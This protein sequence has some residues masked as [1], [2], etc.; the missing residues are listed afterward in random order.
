MK[1]FGY[2]ALAAAVMLSFSGCNDK[3]AT[4][5]TNIDLSSYPIKTDET[6][7]YWMPLDANL[8][9]S[10]SNFGETEYAKELEKRTGVKIEYIHPAAG[11]QSEAL[12]VMIASDELTD[13]VQTDWQ[14]GY[15][16]GPG[17]AISDEVIISLNDYFKKYA[18]SFSKVLSEHPEINKEIKTDEGQYYVFPMLRLS[19]KVRT[20]EG[21]VLRADWLRELNLKAPETI[22][23]WEEVLRAFKDKKHAGAPMCFNYAYIYKFINMMGANNGQYVKDGKIIY[24]PTE[25]E[26]KDA[27]ERMRKW[28]KEGLLDKNIASVDAKM[29]DAN[30]LNGNTGAAIMTGG[31]GIGKYLDS[32]E[33]KNFDL[34][35]VKMPGISKGES[36]NQAFL[37]ALYNVSGSVGISS[38]C[39]NPALAV[40]Y[41]DYNYSEEGHM[42]ANF[43]IDGISYKMENDYPVYT[44]LITKNPEGKAMSQIMPVYFRSSTSGPFIQD[45]RYIEQYYA[46]PQQKHAL[47]VWGLRNEK[48]NVSALPPLTPSS[49]EADELSTLMASIDKYNNEMTIK[50]ITGVESLDNYDAYIKRLK[51]LKIDRVI[52]IM[53]NAYDRYTNR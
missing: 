20:S 18:P 11:Q 15:I 2:F 38:R 31:S 22:E 24:G 17:K 6:L 41:M 27:L 46:K 37:A 39:K 47:E 7:T 33:D 52:E 35:A 3:N 44:S 30:I 19:D 51:D 13:L 48:A 36:C 28:Y 12:S 14:S 16:G 5:N 40:K 8:T 53:Q 23:E 9:T 26:Y 21:P 32:A 45:E 29:L 50:F 25:P 34:V 49:E 4:S 1:R 42:L 43:G 10:V